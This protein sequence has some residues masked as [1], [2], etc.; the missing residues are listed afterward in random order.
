ML[1]NHCLN[2]H[3]EFQLVGS[4]SLGYER[5]PTSSWMNNS[6][7]RYSPAPTALA[8]HVKVLTSNAWQCYSIAV[9]SWDTWCFELV[10]QRQVLYWPSWLMC[11]CGANI[12]GSLY[13][14]YSCCI[15]CG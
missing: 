7:P 10:S 14:V 15:Q 11:P 12:R 1:C 2:T 13:Q 8:R 4:S 3:S 5:E 9:K 6:R